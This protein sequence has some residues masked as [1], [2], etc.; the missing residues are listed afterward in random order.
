MKEKTLSRRSLIKGGVAVGGAAALTALVGCSSTG[1]SSS[2]EKP[3]IPAEWDGEADIVAIGA[4]GAGLA[5]GIEA[6]TQGVSIIIL[7]SEAV[8]GGNSAI[9]NGGMALP[10]SPLQAELGVEDSADIYYDDLIDWLETDYVEPYVRLVADLQGGDAYEWL[11]NQGIVF[12]ASGVLQTN[13]ASRPREHHV[14][15]GQCMSM[16]QTNAVAAGAEIRMNTR[17]T[18]LIRDLETKRVIGVEAVNNG[19]TQYYK[20]K[21]GVLLCCGG[22]GRNLDMLAENNFGSPVNEMKAFNGSPGQQGD[23]IKMAM[24]IGADLKKMSYCHLLTT[25]NP[26]GDKGADA[27]M[28]HQGGVLVNIDGERFVDES[29]GYT[30]VWSYL[31]NQPEQRCFQVWDQPI[32]DAC[33][34]NASGYYSMSKIEGTGFML[35]ADT[36]EELAELMGVPSDAFVATMD[37]YNNDI[38]SSGV[39]NEYGRQVLVGTGGTPLALNHPPYY[40]FETVNVMSMTVG[41][42]KRSEEDILQAADVWGETIDGL[43]LAG[44]ISDYCNFGC[45][46]GTRSPINASGCSFGPAISFGRYC[47]QEMAKRDNWDEA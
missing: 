4:G 27:A 14:D 46:P 19:E 22:Y 9:C 35:K 1:A 8:S 42:V 18:H 39:D 15:P 40:A 23:G 25:R 43:Y 32:A 5:A 38:E 2:S 7:E 21:K 30:R 37:L 12:E 3:W 34:D 31:I 28:Y 29:L 41:G 10:G 16:L 36:Y 33:A 26:A 13:G 44:N 47:V 6:Q 17:A 20:A 24:E 45:V 11:L